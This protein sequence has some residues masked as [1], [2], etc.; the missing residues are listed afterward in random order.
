[1]IKD[2]WCPRL[3]AMVAQDPGASD[4]TS[5]AELCWLVHP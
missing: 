5:V 3:V 4:D 2:D 1:M